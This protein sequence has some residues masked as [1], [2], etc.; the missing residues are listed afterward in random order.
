MRD[1]AQVAREEL[2]RRGLNCG[3]D[4]AAELGAFL[5]DACQELILDGTAPERAAAL[6]LER[7]GDWARLARGLRRLEEAPMERARRLWIPGLVNA[8]LAF[9]VLRVATAAG[10]EPFVR[11]QDHGALVVYWQWLP[12]LP[13][14]AAVAAWWS[15]RR[16][17]LAREQLIAGLFPSLAMLTL[18]LLGLVVSNAAAVTI[19]FAVRGSARAPVPLSVQLPTL[20]LYLLAWVVVPGALSLLGVLPLMFGARHR[21]R[22]VA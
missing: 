17:G 14:F 6:T 3:D 13:V 9:G 22:A 4:V 10:L 15:A 2:A 20:G 7:A 5:D 8:A 11:L 16:G 21:H 1:W 19:G 18:M 12:A